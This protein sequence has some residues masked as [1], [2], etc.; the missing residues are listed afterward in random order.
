MIEN[1]K[2]NQPKQQNLLARDRK[3]MLVL[4]FQIFW[5]D[6]V[7]LQESLATWFLGHGA[8]CLVAFPQSHPRVAAI[9][10]SQPSVNFGSVKVFRT[11]FPENFL[12]VALVGKLFSYLFKFNFGLKY[13]V[14]KHPAAQLY[15]FN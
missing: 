12:E 3:E 8:I 15:S 14:T 9:E 7:D 13:Q 2:F 1:I 10:S 5:F 11:T 4:K 6:Y